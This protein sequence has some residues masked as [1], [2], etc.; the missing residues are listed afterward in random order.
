MILR[1]LFK[2]IKCPNCKSK[3]VKSVAGNFDG[4]VLHYCQ[5]CSCT[6]VKKGK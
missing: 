5:K 2:R 1:S 3:D 6:F 4:G